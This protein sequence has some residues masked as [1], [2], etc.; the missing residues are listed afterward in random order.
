MASP[1]RVAKIK[2]ALPLLLLGSLLA[3][4]G[5]TAPV[6]M[7]DGPAEVRPLNMT[8]VTPEGGY[9]DLIDLRGRPVLLYLFAT[10][11]MHSQAALRP[12]GRFTRLNPH[13]HVIGVAVQPRARAFLDAWRQALS[14]P[15]PVAYEPDNLVARGLSR[16]GRLDG[17]PTFVAIDARGYVQERYTGFINAEQILSLF[18]EHP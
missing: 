12:L 16:L 10:F 17:V 2:I 1:A 3:C 6:G 8:F 15:F 9:V 11:D 4:G 14:P 7:S 18:G 13:I 5:A